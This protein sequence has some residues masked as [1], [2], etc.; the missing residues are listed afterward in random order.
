MDEWLDECDF[1]FHLAGVNRPR[2]PAE[3]NAGNAVFTEDILDRLTQRAAKTPI[4]LTSSIQAELDNPYGHSKKAAEDAVRRYGRKTGA[5]IYVYRL[6]NVFGKWCRPNYNS[7]IATWCHNIA[8]DLPIVVH[9]ESARIRLVHVDD[10]VSDFIGCLMGRE[11]SPC[12]VDGECLS[13]LPAYDKTLGEIVSLLRTFHDEPLTLQVP[14]QADSFGKKLYATYLSY[15]PE[16]KF[17]YSVMMHCDNRGSFTELLHTAERGQFSVNISKPGVVKGQHW[18]HTKHE[19]FCVVSGRGI[20]RFRK[21][22]QP[23]Q[24]VIECSVSGDKIEIVR[25]PPG[26]THNIVNEG[27]VD[28]VTLMWA[29]EVY[30]PLC[31]DTFFEKV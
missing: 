1:V 29:N 14:N 16:D 15:L 7:A 28:M 25:V 18:H 19:K 21:V 2:D 12:T 3:F 23:S 27:D 10:V 24:P 30:D 26:Y 4:L 17:K 8:R 11:P 9:D 22:D 6:P 5:L 31:P 13:V 20:V